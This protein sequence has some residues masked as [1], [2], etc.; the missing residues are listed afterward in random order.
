MFLILGEAHGANTNVPITQATGARRQSADYGFST[1]VIGATPLY[2]AARYGEVAI[3]RTL[4]AAGG[5][6]RFA[7]PNG[8]GKVSMREGRPR[9]DSSRGAADQ[10]TWLETSRAD[11]PVGPEYP[12]SQAQRSIFWTR[13]PLVLAVLLLLVLGYLNVVVFW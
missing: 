13:G 9:A 7:M 8:S 12:V 10:P 3:M 5:D 6:L 11:V 4:A 2:L 1:N